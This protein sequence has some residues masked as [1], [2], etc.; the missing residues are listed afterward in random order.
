VST[1][2]GKTVAASYKDLLQISNNNIGVDASVRYIEDGEGTPSVLGLSTSIVEVA[3]AIIP[4]ITLSRDLGSNTRRFRDL[5]L[6]GSTIYLGDQELKVGDI[7]TI[8]DVQNGAYATSTQG[9]LA[10]SAL[11]PGDNIDFTNIINRPTTVAGYG[12]TD[13]ADQTYVDNAILLGTQSISW[14]NITNSPNTLAGYGITDAATSTQGARADTAL[15]PGDEI[16]FGD[17]SERP[18]TLAGYGI[19]DAATSTQGARADTAL[20]PGDGLDFTNLINKPTTLAGYGITDAATTAYVDN[21]VVASQGSSNWQNIVNTPTTL[22]GYGI[23]DAATSTQGDKADSALQPGD[24]VSFTSITNRPNTLAGYGITDAATT[25]Y[26]DQ[27][28]LAV[29]GAVS[30]DSITSKPTTLAGFGIVDAATSAQ[31]QTADEAYALASTALQSSDAILFSSLSGI[32]T[33]LAGYGITDAATSAQGLL[34]ESALQPGDVDVDLTVIESTDIK[35]VQ[36]SAQEL[37]GDT[38]IITQTLGTPLLTTDR[39][40]GP[41]ELIID[42]AGIGDVSGSVRVLGDL[43]VDGVTT[44]VNSINMTVSSKQLVVAQGAENAFDANQAGLIVNGANATMIYNA[45]DDA[46][47]FNKALSLT[48]SIHWNAGEGN[49]IKLDNSFNLVFSTSGE[50]VFTYTTQGLL[51]V[52]NMSV[53]LGSESSHW[54]KIYGHDFWVHDTIQFSFGEVI[55]ADAVSQWNDNLTTVSENSA[56]WG[57]TDLGTI[58]TDID[59][60]SGAIDSLSGAIDT[61]TSNI[62]N[63]SNSITNNTSDII[64]VTSTVATNSAAWASGG[65]GGTGDGSGLQSRTTATVT[66]GVIA[67]GQS[68]NVEI[69]NV[70]RS[71]LI[72]KIYT[73]KAAWVTLYTDSVA[74]T[75]DATRNSLTDPVPGTGVIAEVVT[76]GAYEQ[77]I[78]PGVIGFNNDTTPTTTAYLKVVNNSGTASTITVTITYVQLEA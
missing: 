66:T 1:L 43:V 18:T 52:T 72:Q 7:L 41:S 32:P 61:N 51:P 47:E 29:S 35:T 21:A 15:Q 78:T 65:G 69:L 49:E 34:A 9:A 25:A 76:T 58:Y 40:N 44:T 64:E 67:D 14:T 70:A 23:T 53:D 46:W 45:N 56:G 57:T 20:Q 59:Y 8:R 13:A 62:S 24:N 37:T 16:L 6:S 75:D 2:T 31:G 11:Q 4:D 48:D 28:I 68:A 27:E 54:M 38:V 10:D 74:R 39:I 77:L 50:D 42:P 30:W 26:V 17:L 3:G 71:Y 73:D 33:T 55:D 60:L 5:Y 63:L 19:T 36:L 12:I 22:D